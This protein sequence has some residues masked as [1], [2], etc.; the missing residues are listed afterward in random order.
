MNGLAFLGILCILTSCTSVENMENSFSERPGSGG[1]KGLIA[2]VVELTDDYAIVEPVEE[3]PE[4]NLYRTPDELK[5]YD[6]VKFYLTPMGE[7]RTK[8][9]EI[10][11][12]ISLTYIGEINIGNPPTIYT[13]GWGHW[14]PPDN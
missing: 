13:V 11:D 5:P 8:D 4:Y 2:E 6:Y 9:I 10:G 1:E 3:G 14:P 12:I 7:D